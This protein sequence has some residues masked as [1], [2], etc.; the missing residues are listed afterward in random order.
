M[1][2]HFVT[3]YSPG[4]MVSEETTQPIDS[5]DVE[6]ATAWASSVVERHGATPFGFQFSTRG[7][8]DDDL[9]SREVKRSGMYYLG[10]T[11]LTLDEV[12]AR[13]DPKDAILIANMRCNNYER[14]V[15]NNNSWKAT[16]P[17]NIDD[18]VLDF[19]VRKE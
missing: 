8:G 1:Q 10:G 3:F 7:R 5:W 12:E 11:V 15:E 18:V 17:L 2:Q 13:D 16:R 4:T 19:T 6:K 9:V 14:I